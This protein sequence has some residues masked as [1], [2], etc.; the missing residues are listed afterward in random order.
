MST[1]RVLLRHRGKLYRLIRYEG[2]YD[3][4]IMAFVDRDHRLADGTVAPN[5]KPSARFS[6]HTSGVVH[7]YHKGK[8]E[9]TIYIEPLYSLSRATTVGFVSVPHPSRLDTFSESSH[10]ADVV[11]A[12]DLPDDFD[13][14]ADFAII[15]GP[16][17]LADG[18]GGIGVTTNYELYFVAT[19]VS[20]QLA[21]APEFNGHFLYALPSARLFDKARITSSEAE[22]NFYKI[23]Y[24]N[25]PPIF[26][27]RSGAYVT[28]AEVP[29]RVSPKLFVIF[30]RAD[31]SIE[32][33]KFDNSRMQP[34]H[35]VRF[36]I[37]DKGGRNKNDDLRIHILSVTLDAEL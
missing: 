10:A 22:L 8:R 32:Q 26:R 19:V 7:Y 24:P 23:A 13:S 27:E 16:K 28:H 34:T 25:I 6:I 29:M 11:A 4:S 33:T 30:D 2:S 1:V 12:L 20:P 5:A 9:R 17:R 21:P 14:R 3:G 35:K 18:I 37:N 15:V 31:L 36:W